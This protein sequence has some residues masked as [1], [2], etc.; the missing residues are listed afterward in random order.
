MHEHEFGTCPECGSLNLDYGDITWNDL[1]LY[2][3][4]KQEVTCE[5]CG[6]NFNEL[7]NAKPDTVDIIWHGNKDVGEKID[8]IRRT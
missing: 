1:T 4:I 5:D 6:C 8:L 7:Y 2:P 3:S